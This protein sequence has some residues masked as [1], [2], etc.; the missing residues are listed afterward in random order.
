MTKKSNIELDLRVKDKEKSD[1]K[2]LKN[3]MTKELVQELEKILLVIPVLINTE[4]IEN[5][6]GLSKSNKHKEIPIRAWSRER[7]DKDMLKERCFLNKKE[8]SRKHILGLNKF[9]KRET[10][11]AVRDHIQKPRI[12]F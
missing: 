1:S 11:E 7:R 9:K 8:N 12:E 5:I 2:E 10:N 6:Q 3:D 4:I